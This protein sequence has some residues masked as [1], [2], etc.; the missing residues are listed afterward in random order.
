MEVYVKKSMTYVNLLIFET[1][2]YIPDLVSILA[3]IPID[4]NDLV[5]D[6]K[7]IP[8]IYQKYQ[9]KYSGISG[10]NEC[11]IYFNVILF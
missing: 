8:K 5:S 2:L 3:V 7:N 9:N 4:T 1:D 10:I 11:S 6:T